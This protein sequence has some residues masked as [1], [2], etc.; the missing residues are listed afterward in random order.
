MELNPEIDTV[1]NL[2]DKK[3]EIMYLERTAYT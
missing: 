3:Q 1:K 2:Y